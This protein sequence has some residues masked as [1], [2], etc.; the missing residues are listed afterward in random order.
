MNT[1]IVVLH[2]G[3]VGLTRKCLNSLSKEK[4][5]FGEIVLVNNDS[6]IVLSSSAF[7][8]IQQKLHIINNKKNLGF[9][10][11]VNVGV[12]F[13]LSK[14]ADKIL[15]L[16][17]DTKILKPILKT[18]VAILDSDKSIGI[19]SPAI[20]F[21][22]N[23]KN[24][25]DVGGKINKFFLRTSHDEVLSVNGLKSREVKYVS[26]AA[27]LIKKEVFKKI[28]F[29][30]ERFFLY[31]E[32]VDFCLRAQK[33]GFKIIVDPEAVILH[34]LSKTIGKVSPLG[35]YYQTKS[36]LVFANKYAESILDRFR[37]LTFLICQNTLIAIK[38]P[39]TG[40]ASI[41]AFFNL[42]LREF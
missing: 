11:G 33:K 28:G 36:A 26:G 14:G 20:Q 37:N 1:S 6:N 19:V 27:M 4:S 30:D 5:N 9:S 35:V 21:E 24:I 10:A 16:N 39:S 42:P 40:L 18:L 17:N 2:Y 13:A 7:P 25:F 41:K 38:Y 32:D 8:L 12:K 3:D 34:S 23:K 22:L 31:Y 29:F 15:I